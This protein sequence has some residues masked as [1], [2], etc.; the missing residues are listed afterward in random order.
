MKVLSI[1]FL[2]I[3]C[4]CLGSPSS[5]RKLSK[6]T[7]NIDQGS[8]SG[9]GDGAI[10]GDGGIDSDEDT[11]Q[12]I[13]RVELRQFIDPND[14]N[15]RTKVTIPKNFSE[16]LYISGLNISSLQDK[17]IWV[18]F[19]LGRDLTEVTLPA[20]VTRVDDIALASLSDLEVLN[21]DLSSRPF[22]DIVLSYDLFDYNDYSSGTTPTQDPTSSGLYCRG[23]AIDYDPT[24]Q[25]SASNARCDATGETCLYAYAKV[26]DRG[27]TDSGTNL[28]VVPSK[29]QIDLS[30]SGYSN[31]SL[32]QNLTKCL[33]DNN[34]LANL[35][36]V[37]GTT[38]AAL[39]IGAVITPGYIYNGPY[40]PINQA[41]WE[42]TGDA[43]FSAVTSPSGLFANA[44]TAGDPS[45]GYTSFLFPRA[46]LMNFKAGREYFGSTNAF[47][48]RTLQRLLTGGDSIFVDGCNLRAV[49]YDPNT[50]EGINS[51]NVTAT[52]EVLVKDKDAAVTDEPVVISESIDLKLQ[53][54]RVSQKDFLGEEILY[55]SLKNCDASSECGNNECCFNKRCWSKE[56]V[57]QCKEDSTSTGNT[58]IGGTCSSDFD[59]A[60]L[61]CNSSTGTCAVHDP[62]GGVYCSKSPGQTCVAKEFCRQES[63]R[64]CFIVK[65]G[66][67]NGVQTCAR[68]CYQVPTFG[69]CVDNTCIQPL[70]PDIPDFDPNDPSF[71]LQAIDPPTDF[72]QIQSIIDGI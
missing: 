53:L 55:T 54:S 49:N 50:N 20:T 52:V 2:L 60:S 44:F 21:V 43:L 32:A 13:T 66:F 26:V 57:S 69:N 68:R 63:I 19:R 70:T 18:R 41:N 67:S 7:D 8:G 23:L 24:F 37:L 34:D 61:C 46:G 51:C 64:T 29:A 35:N 15:F 42:I 72:S 40:R 31:D 38:A 62:V 16:R 47:D 22:E 11:G 9:D 58:G 28:S 27:L 5:S 25:S 14:G 17:F 48:I 36:G 10:G 56:I 45:T 30:D 4:S 71:C 39:T 1:I 33:P 12:T 65:T 59:C 6:L 3:L